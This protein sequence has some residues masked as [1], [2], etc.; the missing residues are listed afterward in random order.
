MFKKQLSINLIAN[1]MSFSISVGISFILTPFL[2]EHIGKE[3]FGFFPLAN[4]FVLYINLLVIALN[5]MAARFIMLEVMKKDIVRSNIYFNSVFYSNIIMVIILI[6]PLS[7]IIIFI[8]NLLNVPVDLRSD[9]KILFTLIFMTFLISVLGSVF[10]VATL[11]TNRIDL[12]SYQEIIQSGLKA[13]LFI[14][15]FSILSPSIIYVGVVGLSVGIIGIAISLYFTK[16]LLPEIKLSIAYFDIKAVKELLSSGIWGSFNQL[17][18]ILL[19]GLDLLLANIFFGAA[20]AGEFSIAQT[21]PLFVITLIG[22]LVGVFFPT[23]AAHYAKNDIYGMIKE[24]DFSGKVLGILISVPIAGFIVF[25][26][27]FYQLWVPSEDSSYLHLLSVIIF[28]PFLVSGSINVLFN[29][30]TIINKVKIP[31][32]VLFC[33]GVLN[34][35]LVLILLNYTELGLLAIPISS[36]ILSFIR[37]LAFTPVYSARC[38]GVKWYNFYGL[39]LR[40]FITILILVAVFYFISQPLTIDTWMDLIVISGICGCI[41]ILISLVLMLNKTQFRMLFNLISNKLKAKV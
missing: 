37:N 22:M 27:E 32:I 8:D 38:L 21:V 36:V 13:I 9:I 31:S 12:R 3:A 28:L 16:K 2:I 41:G 18:S 5:S 25:G 35:V 14:V 15:L 39:I 23:I 20:K 1:I 11:A 40:N 10:N 17:S 30:N 19:T 33:T 24:I 6:I 7:L 26:E 29:V 34:V 4:N